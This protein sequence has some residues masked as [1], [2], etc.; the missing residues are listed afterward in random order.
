MKKA[1]KM[2]MMMSMECKQVTTTEMRKMKRRKVSLSH[3]RK[4]ARKRN[5]RA[6]SLITKNSPISSRVIFMTERV[7]RRN[8]KVDQQSQPT[9]MTTMTNQQ[10]EVSEEVLN[11]HF[12]KEEAQAVAAVEDQVLAEAA[13]EDQM[14][15]E[16][17]VETEV[18]V[19]VNLA[20]ASM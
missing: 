11:A 19:I 16:D 17:L 3:Q 1:L 14:L 20:E 7:Q 15:V 18:E 9:W 5:Q 10:R 2:R 12:H 13:V 8:L 6:F 4:T